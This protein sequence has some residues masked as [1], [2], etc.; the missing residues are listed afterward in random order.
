MLAADINKPAQYLLDTLESL[1]QMLQGQGIKVQIGSG[2]GILLLGIV[3][4]LVAI[5]A[6][7]ITKKVLEKILKP[8][9]R[10]TK[11]DW[12][13]IALQQGFFRRAAHFAP[14]MVFYLSAPLF[15]ISDSPWS[16][17]LA[18]FIARGALV[19][20]TFTF[21]LVGAAF[22]NTLG[23]LYRNRDTA[24]HRPIRS[25][26][27]VI[28]LFIY[29]VAGILIVSIILNKSPWGFLTGLGAMTAIILLVFKDTILGLVASVQ[30]SAYDSIRLGDWIEMPKYGVDGDVIMMSLNQIRVQNW[31][32]TIVT[33]PTYAV[34][35]DSVKN[36]RGM[37]ESG[38]RRIKRH[39]NIDINT[40]KFCNQEMLDRFAKIGHIAEYIQQKE[41]EIQKH[42]QELGIEMT[43]LADGRHLTNVGTF[44]AYVESYLRDHSKIHKDMTFLIRQLQ[45][46]SEGL[47]L[48]IYVFTND[49]KW[50]NYE[51]IQADIFDHIFAVIPLFDLAAFQNTS[52][53]NYKV[54]IV[55]MPK[56]TP[57]A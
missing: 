54:D 55:S 2:L 42:N 20:F 41:E 27:Q 29:I 8:I 38:G 28:K 34:L 14:A 35:T 53:Q 15:N 4:I 9:I 48:E 57:A 43:S 16:Q 44:R 47:P 13:N 5:V 7:Y 52:G 18:E 25:Y 17:T 51:A 56:P 39:I 23:A 22:T 40:I 10:R 1:N 21:A 6:D 30:I 26:L 12:D 3:V 24:K 50:A 46:T 45:P 31:D 37:S 11:V 33:V 32:K 36:W 19:Y 49:I